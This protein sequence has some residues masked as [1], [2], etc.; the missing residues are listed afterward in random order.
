MLHIA[1][2]VKKAKALF[3]GDHSWGHSHKILCNFTPD[4][5][6]Y[7]ADWHCAK[8]VIVASDTD[9]AADTDSHEIFAKVIMLPKVID[10]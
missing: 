3:S 1:G 7:M 6:A 10:W 8:L 9:S 4:A 2:Q 5:S